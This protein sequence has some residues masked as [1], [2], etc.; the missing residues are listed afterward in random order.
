MPTLL[1]DRDR[2]GRKARVREGPDGDGDLLFVTFLDVEDRLAAFGAEGEP[3]SCAFVSDSDELRAVALYG[4]GLA[5]KARLR[6]KDAAGPALTSVAVADGD[7][8][9]FSVDLS[10]KLTAATRC[11]A[12]R[13]ADSQGVACDA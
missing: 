6:A 8:D 7:T 2:R 5:G 9:W 1:V 12:N 3:E 10:P 4:H 11:D 13:H